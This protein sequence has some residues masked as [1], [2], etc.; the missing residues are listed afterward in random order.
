MKPTGKDEADRRRRRRA[1]RKLPRRPEV[2]L[3]QAR[4]AAT[5]SAS[6]N[7]LAVTTFGGDL[8]EREV[9]VVPGKGKLMITGLLG[10]G[11]QE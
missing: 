7:G 9:T 11:M 1:C 8:L 5:R 10:E 2:P 6:R 4:G 3:G